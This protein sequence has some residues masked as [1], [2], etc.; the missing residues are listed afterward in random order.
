[1]TEVCLSFFPLYIYDR[2]FQELNH[3]WASRIKVALYKL[4][5]KNRKN[6]SEYA[7]I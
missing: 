5:F 7:N 4:L 2:H 1:M 6:N 3:L